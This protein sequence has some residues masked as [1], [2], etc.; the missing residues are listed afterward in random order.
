MQ[1]EEGGSQKRKGKKD[2]EKVEAEKKRR[3]PTN[4]LKRDFD[5][6]FF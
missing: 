3:I 5:V 4:H 6:F 1:K 2:G